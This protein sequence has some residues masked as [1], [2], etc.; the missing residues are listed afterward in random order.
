MSLSVLQVF[1]DKPT[2]PE[3]K[4]KLEFDFDESVRWKVKKT[5]VIT[6]YLEGDMIIATHLMV[7]E[8]FK[9]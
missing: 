3:F 9:F 6:V 4:P 1:G 2:K 8:I 7:V 5:Q